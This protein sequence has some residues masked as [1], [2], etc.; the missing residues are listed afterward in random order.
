[1]WALYNKGFAFT[2]GL[3][4]HITL[5]LS[6]TYTPVLHTC[7]KQVRHPV[8]S[9]SIAG[10]TW[11]AFPELPL[12][13]STATEFIPFVCLG[14]DLKTM[15][16]IIYKSLAWKRVMGGFIVCKYPETSLSTCL[17]SG[18][19]GKPLPASHPLDFWWIVPQILFTLLEKVLFLF[20]RNLC[21]LSASQQP[22]L[23]SLWAPRG[24]ASVQ[25]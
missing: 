23:I 18:V 14:E 15:F 24:C 13:L 10:Y 3:T 16:F 1:M 5:I 8:P 2:S 4:M 11:R 9:G 7:S 12:R 20:P 22:A 6:A 19:P 17:C 25:S 21:A